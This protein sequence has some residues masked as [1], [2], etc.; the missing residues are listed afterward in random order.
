MGGDPAEVGVVVVGVA[1]QD[2]D[3]L[4][5]VE[6]VTLHEDS[7]G[8]ADEHSAAERHIELILVP[9]RRGSEYG[10]PGNDLDIGDVGSG[11][12]SSVAPV[13]VERSD[14]WTLAGR[15]FSGQDAADA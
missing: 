10:M 4:V 1:T 8:L 3:R 13:A 5:L 7:L 6:V 2:F 9:C 14:P 15:Q 11:E 12:V